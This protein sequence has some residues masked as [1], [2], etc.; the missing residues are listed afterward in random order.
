MY[1]WHLPLNCVRDCENSEV[2]R[3]SRFYHQ[4]FGRK[5]KIEEG[6]EEEEVESYPAAF[7]D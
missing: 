1:L 7:L 5:H 3:S 4:I 2:E 6:Q